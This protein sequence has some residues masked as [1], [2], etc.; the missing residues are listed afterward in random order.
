MLSFLE[1]RIAALR[2]PRGEGRSLSGK[3][4][5][6]WRYRFGKYRIICD[7][8]NEEL[9]IVVVKVGKRDEVYK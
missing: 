3:W 1:E 2:D 4:R 5:G 9:T 7:I 6:F 8:I